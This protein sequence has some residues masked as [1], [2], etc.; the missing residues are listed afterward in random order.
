[1]LRHCTFLLFICL[2]FW[3]NA[4]YDSISFPLVNQGKWSIV[5]NH[6]VIKVSED[7]TELSCFDEYG[8]AF[9]HD[10]QGSGI[11]DEF[12][13][14]I[15]KTKS[16]HVQQL[17]NGAYAFYEKK[18][19]HL[20]SY[21]TNLDIKCNELKSLNTYWYTYTIGKELYVI[22]TN[23]SEGKKVIP[24]INGSGV[25][26]SF[27]YLFYPVKDS[28][29][30]FYNPHGDLIDAGI[31]DKTVQVNFLCAMGP[32]IS[33]LV[34]QY[35]KHDIPRNATNLDVFADSYTYSL[36]S[37]A[38]L[39]DI[40]TDEILF[41]APGDR[42]EP[43]FGF[44]DTLRKYSYYAIESNGF[45]KLANLAGNTVLNYKYTDITAVK[46]D[47][48]AYYYADL[49]EF[50]GLLDINFKEL[51]PC[52]Y[53]YI[54]HK[55]QFFICQTENNKYG[56]YNALSYDELLLP[57]YNLIIFDYPYIKAYENDRLTYLKLN[58][59]GKVE[60]KLIVDNMLP[61]NDPANY[62]SYYYDKRLLKQGW[63]FKYDSIRN[64]Y[65]DFEVKQVKWGLR[66]HDSIVIKPTYQQPKY[67]KGAHFNTIPFTTTRIAVHAFVPY[68]VRGND[69]LFT[70]SIIL[71]NQTGKRTTNQ[72]ILKLDT[73]FVGQKT[74]WRFFGTHGAGIVNSEG[75]I[76]NYAFVEA[77]YVGSPT[78]VCSGK[79]IVAVEPD[80]ENNEQLSIEEITNIGSYSNS[81]YEITGAQW[82]CLDDNG[83]EIFSTP[84][85]YMSPYFFNR[86]I[87]RKASKYG[88]VN[89]NQEIVLPTYS[90]I[91]FQQFN[92]QFVFKVKLLKNQRQ[93]MDTNMNQLA[94][95][96]FEVMKPLGDNL[97]EIKENSK[98][99]VIDSTR[100]I[101]F[102]DYSIS[103]VK[104]P[105]RIVFKRKKSFEIRD[106]KLNLVGAA[107]CKPED[108]LTDSI[109]TF[110]KTKLGL[111]NIQG[112]TLVTEKYEHIKHFGNYFL[113]EK[114]STTE[115][116]D[117]KGKLIK[118]FD[119]GEIV[120]DPVRSSICHIDN[121][122]VVRYTKDLKKCK[123]YGIEKSPL[124]LINSFLFLANGC[125]YDTLGN[126][127]K[128]DFLAHDHFKHFEYIAAGYFT[129]EDEFGNWFIT[130][131]DLNLVSHVE[132]M[133]HVK[134]LEGDFF[135]Y[136]SKSQLYITN[137]S[138]EV[139]YPI[140]KV[141]GTFQ[142]DLILVRD[143]YGYCYLNYSL[144]N[145]FDTHY[146]EA[147][148]FGGNYTAVRPYKNWGIMNREG[149]FTCSLEYDAITQHTDYLFEIK[150]KPYCGLLDLNGNV[151]IE[152]KYERLLLMHNGLI[153][154][155]KNGKINYFD[156][157]GKLIL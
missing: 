81:R 154:V 49:N 115:I 61:I 131:L 47:N 77:N 143:D 7:I 118:T 114:G 137:I 26:Q 67:I 141:I 153:Q 64:Q 92:N 155:Y 52:K 27:N 11:I 69:R 140:K 104:A 108:F 102:N 94:S 126:K 112:D 8:R 63:F 139:S 87:V 111:A 16:H 35:G 106:E 156:L 65:G 9:F 42:I 149:N 96:N 101:I 124:C 85:D 103:Y 93:F 145:E 23:W 134:H 4:Q 20:K 72:M 37:I 44:E 54:D 119:S 120:V 138:K 152:P 144:N 33:I 83:Q 14:V 99:A 75:E 86:S 88:V 46:F 157:S 3:S 22:H 150:E 79:E 62:K 70:H 147:K 136:T 107:S 133:K 5:R 105:N 25:S 110:G 10:H 1:M 121:L 130:D 28:I 29:E 34:D 146:L 78:R 95:L 89:E 30:E 43:F 84:Y 39:V 32:T 17:S 40:K 151:L 48:K 80:Y 57:I 142:S 56:L 38:Y 127:M 97:L 66:I 116:I 21:K 148:P 98:L 123:S 2:V 36:S 19:I 100:T 129:L 51:I 125:I 50:Q 91:A 59:A 60:T 117:S 6:Q 135:T 128:L 13:R 31:F 76:K 122:K 58:K 12:G 82:N 109:F 74:F 90:E 53:K 18:S 55:D 71:N 41:R 132:S 15:Y 73:N 45:I 113:L 68:A 24:D